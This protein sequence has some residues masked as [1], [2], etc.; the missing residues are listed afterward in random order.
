MIFMQVNYTL[1]N[2]PSLATEF[3]FLVALS[4]K[5]NKIPTDIY[6]AFYDNDYTYNGVTGLVNIKQIVR[7]Y[8]P[9]I[10]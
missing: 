7:Y 5:M 9:H 1:L 8:G 4:N 10:G 3:S 6:V 2:I